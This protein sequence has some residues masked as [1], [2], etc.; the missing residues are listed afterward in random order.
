ME[1]NYSKVKLFVSQ[2]ILTKYREDTFYEL[3]KKENLDLFVAFGDRKSKRFSRFS[4]IK[5]EP[6]FN[7]KRLKSVSIIFEKFN[8]INQFFFSPGVLFA[9]AKFKP[10]VV[11][12]EGTSNIVNNLLVCSYCIM[13]K[14]P[15]VWWDLG[16]I[17]GQNSQ[18]IFRRI[19]TPIINFYIKH[20]A[21]ILGYSTFAK[22][23]FMQMGIEEKKITVAYNTIR[24]SHHIDYKKANAERASELSEKLKT[25]DKFVFIT[26]GSVEKQKRFDRLIRAF[27]KLN[28]EEKNIALIIVGD[29]AELENLKLLANGN[30][31]IIFAGS[32][33]EDVGLYFM[34]GNVFVL[35]GLG[36]LSIN[37][38]MTYEM[39]V[40]SAPADGTELDLIKN[41]ETGFLL[42]TSSDDE[43][44]ERMK[45]C[46]QNKEKMSTMGETAYK[47]I[48]EN[49]SLENMINNIMQSVTEAIDE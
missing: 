46:C 42:E 23:Y 41:F 36:G 15:Y 30:E 29:G 24:L 19:L 35:P 5:T 11:L 28:K 12:T 27:L 4:S 22:K 39:P 31:N 1:K 45:W 47:F 9:L 49:Y 25:S 26:V 2:R 20:S 38:A 7:H 16:I 13:R 40:I 34:Q 6:R 33:F 48:T 8:N 44:Y 3:S 37:E 14:I 21:G 18:N 32:Q 43:L 17:R 10:D